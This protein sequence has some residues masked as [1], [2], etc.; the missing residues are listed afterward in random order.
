M[1]CL[2]LS[3]SF[4][5][6]Y[7]L[8]LSVLLINKGGIDNLGEWLLTLCTEELGNLVVSV[9]CSKRSFI[10]ILYQMPCSVFEQDSLNWLKYWLIFRMQLLYPDMTEHC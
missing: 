1:L 8:G 9:L 2:K 4:K 7:V 5:L 3:H 10:L 6:N